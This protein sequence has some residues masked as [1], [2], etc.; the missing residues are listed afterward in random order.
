[1]FGRS[2][3]SRAVWTKSAQNKSW[4]MW[5]QGCA[6]FKYALDQEDVPRN[7]LEPENHWC[8]WR[9]LVFQMS[10]FRP[11]DLV[12]RTV[13]LALVP[14]SRAG[15]QQLAKTEQRRKKRSEIGAVPTTPCNFLRRCLRW[16]RGSKDRR[17]T[18][19]TRSFGPTSSDRS[20]RREQCRAPT[21][22][23]KVQTGCE[24]CKGQNKVEFYWDTLCI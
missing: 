14:M 10:I 16:V 1:M 6:V 2:P 15:V 9:K 22:V 11:H 8:S 7:F 5:S 17:W 4:R 23:E 12:L 20:R 3:Y 24:L 18:R 19:G 21:V 13:Y